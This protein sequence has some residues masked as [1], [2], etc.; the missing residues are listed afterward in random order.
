M[1][2]PGTLTEDSLLDARGANR[3]AA[4]SVRSGRAA[5]AS[6]ELSTGEVEVAVLDREALG[7]ALAALAPA[8]LLCP[9]RL[10]ADEVVAAA[11]KAVGAPVSPLPSALAEPGAAEAR[12]RRLYGV[13]HPRRLRRLLARRAVRAGPPGRAPGDHA[14]GPAARPVAAPPRGARAPRC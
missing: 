13:R 9:D 4:V 3:L 12:L 1:V 11:L 6:V 2:T 5:L 10:F 7:P 14:G 8:E